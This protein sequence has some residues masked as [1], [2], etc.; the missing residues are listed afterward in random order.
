MTISLTQFEHAA[1]KLEF[2]KVLHRVQ[3]YASSEPG[4]ELLSTGGFLF[5][6]PAIKLELSRVSDVKAL[7]EA[8][9]ELPIAG[10]HPVRT[11]LQKSGIEGAILQPKEVLQ[12][13]L[14]IK[15]ARAVREFLSKRK[16]QA[17]FVW[18][19]AGP[20]QV[21]KVLMYNIERAIDESGAVKANA[22]RELQSVS[23]SINEKY[24]ELRKRLEKIL[25][26]VSDQG[27]SRTGR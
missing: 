16:T 20:L 13:G 14:T 12:I 7:I 19:I 5:S 15:A 17:L 8:E 3:R 6:L 21:D 24:D 27:F 2:E 4:R 25:K 1:A 26:S 10:I 9:G 23:R 22:S 11:S 18:E